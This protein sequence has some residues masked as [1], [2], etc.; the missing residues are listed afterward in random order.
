[1]PDN[2]RKMNVTEEQARMFS[3]FL[4]Y[5]KGDTDYYFIERKDAGK[6]GVGKYH[7]DPPKYRDHVR[8]GHFVD[9][10]VCPAVFEPVERQFS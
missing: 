4:N 1:M 7:Y 10:A 8:G 3:E 9:W 2:W 6:W 5:L